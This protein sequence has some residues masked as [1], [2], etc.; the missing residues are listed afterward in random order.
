MSE[1]VQNAGAEEVS[2]DT[3]IKAADTVAGNLATWLIDRVRF[4]DKTWEQMTQ[5]EQE[6]WIDAAREKARGVARQTVSTIASDGR[7]V[8][9]ATLGDAK[10]PADTI[11]P[12]EFKVTIPRTDE[13]RHTAM[14]HVGG[15]VLLVVA[16]AEAYMGGDVPEADPDQPGLMDDVS[17]MDGG[18]GFGADE[19]PQ[20]AE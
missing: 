18:Q 19:Q 11:K 14:D 17:V 16:D 5:E 9:Y 1:D 10:V 13:Q 3:I 20:A 7:K 4:L 6:G 8:I 2:E 15:R 12:I